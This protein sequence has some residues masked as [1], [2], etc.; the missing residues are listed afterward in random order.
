MNNPKKNFLGSQDTFQVATR[1]EHIRLDVLDEFVKKAYNGLSKTERA[2]IPKKIWGGYKKTDLSKFINF[3]PLDNKFSFLTYCGYRFVTFIWDG[4]TGMGVKEFQKALDLY[5]NTEA[6]READDII[7]KHKVFALTHYGVG[8]WL[9]TGAYVF[10]TQLYR[11]AAKNYAAEFYKDV[12]N[13]R[14]ATISGRS[15][16]NWEVL[17]MFFNVLMSGKRLWDVLDGYDLNPTS[18]HCL[19]ILVFAEKPMSH[20]YI[21]ETAGLNMVGTNWGRST[22][23]IKDLVRLGMAEENIMYD[24]QVEELSQPRRF[25]TYLIS[26]KGNRIFMDI[27]RDVTKESF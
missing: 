9:P 12:T 21:L 19:G 16:A 11:L 15:E 13:G 26:P 5:L 18:F 7:H 2:H 17:Q 20:N 4:E 24:T 6:A 3:K 23:H 10:N 22:K 14:M 8:K 25:N 27:M 1:N